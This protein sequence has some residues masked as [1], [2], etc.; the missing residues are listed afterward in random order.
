MAATLPILAVL[1]FLLAGVALRLAALVRLALLTVL[2][3]DPI[4]SLVQP[5]LD[6]FFFEPQD[7]FEGF[8]ELVHRG[9][10]VMLLKL[11]LAAF[12]EAL[13]HLLEAHEVL[14]PHPTLH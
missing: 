12:A 5:P 8:L 14:A 1:T 6:P 10:E 2:G 13:H 11:L 3:I 9:V 4:A 7:L